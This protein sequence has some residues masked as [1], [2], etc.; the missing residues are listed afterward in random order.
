[1][2]LQ[3]GLLGDFSALVPTTAAHFYARCCTDWYMN[4]SV[5]N[6]FFLHLLLFYLSVVMRVDS[7]RT[8]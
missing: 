3:K 2:P 1:P 7:R 5:V 8:S 4:F 6:A